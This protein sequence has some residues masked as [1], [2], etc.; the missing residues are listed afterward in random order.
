MSS[1]DE[2]VSADAISASQ[3]F[4]ARDYEE[5]NNNRG[6]VEN[7]KTNTVRNSFEVI[8]KNKIFIEDQIGGATLADH[9]AA[10]INQRDLHNGDLSELGRN[11]QML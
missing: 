6:G 2:S 8:K 11:Q 10:H 9:V 7:S 1:S 5:S 4:S 3:R